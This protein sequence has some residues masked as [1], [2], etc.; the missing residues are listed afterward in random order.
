M[1][2]LFPVLKSQAEEKYDQIPP[3]RPKDRQD[4]LF[5]LKIPRDF[6]EIF[7]LLIY[8]LIASWSENI[9]W[10]P[11]TLLNILKLALQP[12][13]WQMSHVLMTRISILMLWGRVLYKCWLD[14]IGLSKCPKFSISLMVFMY[15][16]RLLLER[17][18][19][20]SD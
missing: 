18:I 15:L 10:M 8:H 16:F 12:R 9:L 2:L 11:W 6:P 7:L 1:S 5:G 19:K 3:T 13:G 14:H 20:I 4:A 17:H